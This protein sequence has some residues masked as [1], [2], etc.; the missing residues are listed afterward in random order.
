MIASTEKFS[1]WACD[2]RRTLEERYGAELLIEWLAGSWKKKHGIEEEINHQAD[3]LRRKERQ[4]NP[5]Y[6][7]RY[8]CKDARRT[9]EVLPEM[10]HFSVTWNDDRPLRDLSFLRFC[11]PLT[12]IEVRNTEIL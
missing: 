2:P 4:L 12:C 11:P 3:R 9:E 6:K 1:D 5:A 8:S 7:P 10:K